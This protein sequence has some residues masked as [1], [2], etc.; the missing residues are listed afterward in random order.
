MNPYA[1]PK[2]ARFQF[3]HEQADPVTSSISYLGKIAS[4]R[5][6]K[7][8][9]HIDFISTHQ[10]DYEKGVGS[11]EI[12]HKPRLWR[13]AR[14][15]HKLCQVKQR[16]LYDPASLG[17]C[18]S[19]STDWLPPSF[20]TRQGLIHFNRF[21]FLCDHFFYFFSQSKSSVLANAHLL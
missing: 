3:V 12:A 7:R 19:N 16:V 9:C 2:R 11:N 10:I 13:I 20:G 18:T 6:L 17:E 15:G 14:A 21:L 8:H 5:H 4:T 1:L